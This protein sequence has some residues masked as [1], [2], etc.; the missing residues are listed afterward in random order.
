MS[1]TS[2]VPTPD[3]TELSAALPGVITLPTDSGWDAARVAW[4]L[5]IDQRPAAVAV[6][7]SV[8]DVQEI[9]AFASHTGLQVTVQASGH[10]A[11]SAIEGAILVRLT[12]FREVSVD[13]EAKILRV[14]AGVKWGEVVPHLDGTGL[15]AMAGSNANVSVAGY[16]L[17]GGHSWFTRR[18]GI[19]AHSIRAVE[20]VD[21]SGAVRHVDADSDSELLWALRGGTGDVGVVLS[22]ELELY[23]AP[24][25]YGG[26]LLFDGSLAKRLLTT[27][28]EVARDSGPDLSLASGVLRMPDIEQVPPPLRGLVVTYVDAVFV[29]SAEE[30]A[31]LLAPFL[32]LGEPMM[33]TLAPFTIGALAAVSAEPVEPAASRGW[34]GFAPEAS[35]ALI[36]GM[37]A[38]V[39]PADGTGATFAQLRVLGGA[40]QTGDWSGGVAGSV[41]E[42]FLVYALWEG[43]EEA[44]SIDVSPIS[45]HAN[46]RAFATFL[47]PGDTLARAYPADALERLAAITAA[48][49]PTDLFL[50]NRAPRP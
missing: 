37:I 15:I 43:G 21:A 40:L 9:V 2:S 7:R 46:D 48:A 32:A 39:E 30:G 12:A 35:E 42:D 5:A 47:M 34:A 25:L 6:P 20:L 1:S 27:T 28:A 13:A 19:A 3:L 33:N 24:E 26:K 45:T 8:A 36:D 16:I 50:G 11:S 23:D 38:L 49:D 29:G 44:G 41:D 14:G 31:S 10:G 22:L 4:N 17:G 18:H